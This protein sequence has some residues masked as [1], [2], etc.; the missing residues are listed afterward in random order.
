LIEGGAPEAFTA[1]AAVL[2][3]AVVRPVSVGADIG[4]GTRDLAAVVALEKLE[5]DV[6]GW[7][8][9]DLEV[10]VEGWEEEDLD[11]EDFDVVFEVCVGA[12]KLWYSRSLEAWT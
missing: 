5:V 11:D 2:D 10:D 7:E 12:T 3:E 6:E 8:E 1:L 4:K 9:E